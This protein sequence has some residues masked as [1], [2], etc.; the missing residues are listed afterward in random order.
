MQGIRS[1]TW[2]GGSVQAN[3][4]LYISFV[5]GSC[6]GNLFFCETVSSLCFFSQIQVAFAVGLVLFIT[7][8]LGATVCSG[9]KTVGHC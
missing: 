6:Q 9:A 3:L 8:E 7:E 2:E 4:Q 5:G 1:Q